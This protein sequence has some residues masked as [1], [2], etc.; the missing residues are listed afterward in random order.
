MYAG[1][2]TA[3]VYVHIG[4]DFIVPTKS[5][6]CI[7]DMDTSTWSKHTRALVQRLVREGRTVELFDDL[8]RAGV[9]CAGELVPVRAFIG[10][11]AKARGTGRIRF[12]LT[13]PRMQA[14]IDG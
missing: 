8:P 14:L 9:L 5:I 1:R 13:A 4:Q 11:T 6:V 3:A 7:I 2:G 12:R 10:N